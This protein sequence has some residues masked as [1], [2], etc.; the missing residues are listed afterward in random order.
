MTELRT[1]GGV[2]SA[3]D[4]GERINPL[5]I[6]WVRQTGGGAPWEFMLWNMDRWNEFEP[7]HSK[8]PYKRIEYREWL[9]SQ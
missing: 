3:L 1:W 5:W 2:K 4:R 9:V 8:R 6:E 7:D